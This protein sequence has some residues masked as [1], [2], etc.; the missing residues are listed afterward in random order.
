MSINWYF[1]NL[2]LNAKRYKRNNNRYFLNSLGFSTNEVNAIHNERK[3][4]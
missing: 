2:S 3:T 4:T 1:K